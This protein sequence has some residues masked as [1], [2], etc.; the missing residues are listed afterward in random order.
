MS[1]NPIKYLRLALCTSFFRSREGS[2]FSIL[3]IVIKC[4]Q[5]IEAV[6]S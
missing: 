4:K 6:T 2:I 1:K 5:I 3:Q